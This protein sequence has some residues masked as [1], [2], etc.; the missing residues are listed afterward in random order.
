MLQF[1]PSQ[2]R[3]IAVCNN[4]HRASQSVMS[5]CLRSPL[6][7]TKKKKKH[8]NSVYY[9]LHLEAHSSEFTRPSVVSISQ[10]QTENL[11]P[12][13]PGSHQVLYKLDRM[14][15]ETDPSDSPASST[16][17]GTSVVNVVRFNCSA[18]VGLFYDDT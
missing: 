18:T 10:H 3:Q 11:L 12:P 7:L 17:P 2:H 4:C 1:L 14:T 6:T 9:H 16:C 13:Y 15:L 8:K 5:T